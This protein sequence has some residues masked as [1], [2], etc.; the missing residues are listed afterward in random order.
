MDGLFPF[1]FGEV[2]F[3]EPEIGEQ[4]FCQDTREYKIPMSEIEDVLFEQLDLT[5]ENQNSCTYG[6]TIISQIS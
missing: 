1:F 6:C 4:F 3:Y 2:R 5:E